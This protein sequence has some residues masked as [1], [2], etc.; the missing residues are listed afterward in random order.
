[1]NQNH[2]QDALARIGS[3]LDERLE[4]YLEERKAALRGDIA[5]EIE[6]QLA[7]RSRDEREERTA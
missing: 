6:R 3:A 5:A 4:S 1:M 7:E 2:L